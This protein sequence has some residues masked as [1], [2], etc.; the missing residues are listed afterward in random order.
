M[1]ERTLFNGV[2]AS[3]EGALK[4]AEKPSKVSAERMEIGRLRAELARVKMERDSRKAE[5]KYAFIYRNR[6][7]WPISVQCRVLRL[8]VAGYY[9]YFVRPL[10][11]A[12][13]HRA[14]VSSTG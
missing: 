6:R 10:T 9:E 3:R 14:F 12:R 7:V 13:M 5:M 1:V 8:S 4:G 2:K 11:K